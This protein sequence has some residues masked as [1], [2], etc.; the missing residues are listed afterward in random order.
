MW[1]AVSKNRNKF[2]KTAKLG[3]WQGLFI[4]K[5]SCQQCETDKITNSNNGL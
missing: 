2:P 5:R 3:C 4:E 1:Y